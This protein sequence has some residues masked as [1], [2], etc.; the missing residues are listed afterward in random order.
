MFGLDPL[1]IKHLKGN[2][3][4]FSE[5]ALKNLFEN[6]DK[7]GAEVVSGLAFTINGFVFQNTM[8]LQK[9][10]TLSSALSPEIF[11]T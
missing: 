4:K 8:W 2:A 6:S 1:V 3:Y 7:Y 5:E 11:Y 10:S 9:P